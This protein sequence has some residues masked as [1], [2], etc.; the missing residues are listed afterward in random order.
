MS[1]SPQLFGGHTAPSPS[2]RS[3][4]SRLGELPWGRIVASLLAVLFLGAQGWLQRGWLYTGPNNDF[5]TFYTASVAEPYAD[6]SVAGDARAAARPYLRP[7]FHAGLLAPLRLLPYPSAYLLWQV[8]MLWCAA[9]FVAWWRPPSAAASLACLAISIP[10]FF[11]FVRG[12]DDAALLLAAAGCVRSVSL[13][14]PFR[15]GLWLSLLAIQ[16]HALLVTPLV[17]FAQR[18]WMALKG[19]AAGLAGFVGLSFV[20]AG[21]DWPWRF[22]AAWSALPPGPTPSMPNLAGA[23]AWVGLDP[24]MAYPVS[25]LVLL[26]VYSV[27][28][29]ESLP[30]GLG[31]ALAAGLLI[32]PRAGFEDTILLLPAALTLLA[33]KHSWA[34]RL[35]AAIALTPLAYILQ[36]GRNAI[37]AA[38]LL[39]TAMVLLAGLP[40]ERAWT[41]RRRRLPLQLG[42]H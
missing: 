16:P 21:W 17:L 2:E 10:L 32:A 12:Q 4:W 25:A 34:V 3:I 37:P 24:A 14:R 39:G 19:L 30:A 15:A 13:N 42:L 9:G 38:V 20:V 22:A 1:S 40:S 41:F 11:A 8:L 33:E 29:R 31:C 7:P 36:G 26:A 18:R 6:A 5:L 27:S 35:A 23:A 28:R